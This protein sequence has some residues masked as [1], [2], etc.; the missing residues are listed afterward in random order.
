MASLVESIPDARLWGN[1][2]VGLGGEGLYLHQ[3]GREPSMTAATA[4]PL[5]G[6]PSRLRKYPAASVT[7]VSPLW[8]ISKT[9]SSLV[10]PNRFLDALRSLYW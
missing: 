10:E 4:E 6:P 3:K 5:T 7:P 8:S 1:P 9:P 2:V